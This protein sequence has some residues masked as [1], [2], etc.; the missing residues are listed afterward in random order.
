MSY[1]SVNLG[2]DCA[3]FGLS[4]A[5]KHLGYSAKSDVIMC[6]GTDGVIGDSL[7][8]MVGSLLKSAVPN[9]YIYGTL[10]KPITALTVVSFYNKIKTMHTKSKILVIDAAV[11]C[12][13]DVGVIRVIDG[14]ICPG[15]GVK[16]N[17]GLIGDIG[18][19]G[20]VTKKSKLFIENLCS[21]RVGLVYSMA[22][23][24]SRSILMCLE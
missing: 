8:P 4:G 11:G 2:D 18:I 22:S 19:I 21:A 15:L 10:D 17:L 6:V 7:A 13:E 23:L 12:C 3:K 5:L 16:K 24:I 14:A 9:M 20:I 1:L